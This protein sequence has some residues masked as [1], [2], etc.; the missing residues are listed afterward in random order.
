MTSTGTGREM[1]FISQMAQLAPKSP[2]TK[3]SSAL[4]RYFFA[5]ARS[6]ARCTW[7]SEIHDVQ[8][9]AT[10]SSHHLIFRKRIA[11]GLGR[12]YR[13]DL[14]RRGLIWPELV[15]REHEPIAVKR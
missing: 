4:G 11:S 6:K 13:N 5:Q 8:A 1:R 9:M 10:S 3:V 12:P 15:V 7:T 14:C 2:A